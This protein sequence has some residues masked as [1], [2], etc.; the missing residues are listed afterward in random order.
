[1]CWHVR[2]ANVCNVRGQNKIFIGAVIFLFL[3]LLII[4]LCSIFQP[5]R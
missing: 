4:N 2:F 3:V 1:V 5:C